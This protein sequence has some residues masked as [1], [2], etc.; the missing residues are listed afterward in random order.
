HEVNGLEPVAGLVDRGALG[1]AVA[2]DAEDA[3]Q[4]ITGGAVERVVLG[5]QQI[6][7]HREA[8]KEPDVL[9]RAR[10]PRVARHQIVRHA[11][12]QEQDAARPAQRTRAAAGDGLEV[13][14]HRGIAVAQPEPSLRRFVEAGDAVEHGGLAGAVR[15]DQRGDGIGLRRE[16]EIL[17]GDEA[18]EAHAQVFDPQQRRVHPRPSLTRSRPIALRSRRNAEGWRVATRPRGFHTMI[19]TMAR[20]NNSMRYWVGSKSG[21]KMPFR[22]SRSRRISVPPIM[23]TAPLATPMV[24]PMP[25]STTMASTVADSMKVKDSG[26]MKPWR[27]AKNEPA[28]PPNRAPVANAVSLVVVVLMPSERQAISSSRSASHARPSG[29]RRSRTVTKDVSRASPRMM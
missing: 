1:L 4:R 20:P 11:L 21:P 12:E 16:R 13:V 27:A 25:P 14:P 29:S 10:D 3:E 19:S 9:E 23:I 22:K 18:P 6:L 24:L 8:G 28:K 17:D 15:S 5:D 7:Q 26:E 2:A